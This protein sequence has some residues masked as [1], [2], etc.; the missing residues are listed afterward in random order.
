[1]VNSVQNHAESDPAGTLGTVIRW[2]LFLP[3]ALLSFA[4]VQVVVVLGLATLT[5]LV[6]LTKL[7]W[8]ASFYEVACYPVC[9]FF[10]SLVFVWI[11]ALAAPAR[12]RKTAFALFWVYS[13]LCYSLEVS[14]IQFTPRPVSQGALCFFAISGALC[15]LCLTLHRLKSGSGVKNAPTP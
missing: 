8:L 12:K 13:I 4:A 1:M 15:G 10:E 2:I 7:F 14:N 9:F 6:R 5:G 11:G 3:A